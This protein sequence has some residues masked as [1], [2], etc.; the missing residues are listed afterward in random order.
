MRRSFEELKYFLKKITSG[1]NYYFT[2]KWNWNKPIEGENKDHKLPLI[3]RIFNQDKPE[4]KKLKECYD[5][6]KVHKG[7]YKNKKGKAF[8]YYDKIYNRFN[9]NQIYFNKVPHSLKNI[10]I[11]ENI[12]KNGEIMCSVCL[13]KF[14]IDE[15]VKQL[16]P[17]NV[18]NL[19]LK[20]IKKLFS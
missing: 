9:P 18:C 7:I 19:N 10:K 16:I 14:K 6:L 15:E 1:E 11:N 12:L 3:K 4:F 13:E 8:I 5:I 20:L 17:C 2:L